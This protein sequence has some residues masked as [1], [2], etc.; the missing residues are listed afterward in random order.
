MLQTIPTTKS[1]L[2]T[3]ESD[4]L[5]VFMGLR[6]MVK[7]QMPEPK[8]ACPAVVGE[9]LPR[10]TREAALEHRIAE[11][12]ASRRAPWAEQLAEA[13]FSLHN[14]HTEAL[15]EAD[16]HGRR[17]HMPLNEDMGADYTWMQ[18]LAYDELVSWLRLEA[19][20]TDKEI[21]ALEQRAAGVPVKDRHC[22]KRARNRAMAALS[23]SAHS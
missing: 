21:E 20:L 4:L 22:L 1:D 13:E 8:P 6:A 11:H 3:G 12:K 7:N 23:N 17:N 10:F 16:G 2:L 18:K 9:T 14:D 19:K 15:K 5:E